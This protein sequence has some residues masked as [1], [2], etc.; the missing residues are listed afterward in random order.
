MLSHV[1]C[2]YATPERKGAHVF[3]IFHTPSLLMGGF[4]V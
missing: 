2:T 4:R 1:S 3:Y